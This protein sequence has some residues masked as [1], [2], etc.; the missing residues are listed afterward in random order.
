MMD[1]KPKIE[2]MLYPESKKKTAVWR[3]FF[4]SKILI[5][6]REVNYEPFVSAL[7][8][9]S[10]PSSPPPP[11]QDAK[12]AMERMLRMVRRVFMTSVSSLFGL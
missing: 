8:L 5:E 9:S 7:L 12:R 4:R 1:R 6:R 2:C 10:P 3:S 11:P